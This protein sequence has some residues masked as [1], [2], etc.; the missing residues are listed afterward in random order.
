MFTVSFFSLTLH[1][2]EVSSFHDSKR[3]ALK[4]ARWLSSQVWA[5]KVKVHMGCQA[6]GEPVAL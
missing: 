3:A 5:S 4:H 2:F 6:G 1:A